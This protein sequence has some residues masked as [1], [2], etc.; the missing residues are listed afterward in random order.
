MQDFLGNT[1][2]VGDAVVFTEYNRHG[3]TRGTVVGFNKAMNM[4][5]VEYTKIGYANPAKTKKTSGYIIKV[6]N[7]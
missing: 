6:E 3:L 2:E 4:V 5:E 7:N 1:L